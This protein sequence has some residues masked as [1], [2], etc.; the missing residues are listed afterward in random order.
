MNVLTLF[1]NGIM[2]CNIISITVTVIVFDLFYSK[3]L[4]YA[5]PL[6]WV[7]Q[8]LLRLLKSFKN[9][10]ANFNPLFLLKIF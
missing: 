8:Q 1:K 6:A 2:Q 9:P 3:F 4:Y 5:P 7:L 10:T